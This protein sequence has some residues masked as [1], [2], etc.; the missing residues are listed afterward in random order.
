VPCHHGTLAEDQAH[1]STWWLSDQRLA[2]CGDIVE[3]DAK[4]HMA[5]ERHG[6]LT[7]LLR[8]ASGAVGV[9]AWGTFGGPGQYAER[10]E[11]VGDRN[12][13]VI[14]TNAREVTQYE[15]DTGETWTSDWNPWPTCRRVLRDAAETAGAA[16]R[17]MDISELAAAAMAA[18]GSPPAEGAVR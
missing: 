7:A 9:L 15:E 5:D 1:G 3:I 8:F 16:V 14:G 4:A 6:A 18:A 11:V 17:V 13:G 2:F 12:Q 10:V